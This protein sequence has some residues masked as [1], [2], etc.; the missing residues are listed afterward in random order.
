MYSLT[1]WEKA[2]LGL[3][4]SL[5]DICIYLPLAGNMQTCLRTLVTHSECEAV[6]AVKKR[7]EKKFDFKVKAVSQGCSQHVQ[8]LLC[9]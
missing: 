7:K 1:Q 5:T 6:K 9:N 3:F 2:S 8:L 4:C